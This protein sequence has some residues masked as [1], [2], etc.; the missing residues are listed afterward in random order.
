MN[1]LILGLI[2][3]ISITS[4]SYAS[5]FAECDY[6]AEVVKISKLATLNVPVTGNMRTNE[7]TYTRVLDLKLTKGVVRP[8]SHTRTCKEQII[9]TLMEK[10]NPYELGQKLKVTITEANSRGGGFSYSIKVK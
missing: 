10:N 9:Q 5:F 6:E 3:T 7:D 2:F 1:K 4:N 8:G